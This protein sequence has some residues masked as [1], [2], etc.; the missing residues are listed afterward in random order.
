MRL[1]QS[2]PFKKADKKQMGVLF[3]YL[4]V[5]LEQ[6]VKDNEL[7]ALQQA[8]EGAYV[9]PGPGGDPIRSGSSRKL[10]QSLSLSLS[11]FLAPWW[12]TSD[13]AL[14]CR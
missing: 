9:E 2:T 8:L 5:C 11:C 7:G 13:V 3:N 1:V 6:V 12:M 14:C 10:P 4:Q